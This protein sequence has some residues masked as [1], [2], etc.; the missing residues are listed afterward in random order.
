MFIDPD[1]FLIFRLEH[2]KDTTR[3]TSQTYVLPRV[4]QLITAF[5]WVASACYFKRSIKRT[6]SH[7]CPH[8]KLSAIGGRK[9]RN[10]VTL[11]GDLT[12]LATMVLAIVFDNIIIFSAQAYQDEMGISF[13]N[14]L[15][16]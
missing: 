2:D 15:S 13:L 5:L 4:L 14:H 1:Y 9:K 6:I 12:M 16:F 10:L 11:D 3:R 7:I 8:G